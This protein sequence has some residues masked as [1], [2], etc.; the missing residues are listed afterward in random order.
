MGYLRDLEK[1]TKMLENVPVTYSF[2]EKYVTGLI[3]AKNVLNPFL[4]GLLLQMMAFH[5]YDTLKIV[6][7]TNDR[8]S[9]YWN[10]IINSPYFWD[11]Q[12]SIRFFGTNSDDISQISSYLEEM[13]ALLREDSDNNKSIGG[14]KEA[15]KLPCRYV[16][17]TDDIDAVR[18]VSIIRNVIESEAY[19]GISLI[20]CTDRLNSLPNEVEHF[21]SID[22][23]SGGV[24]EKVLIDDKKINFIPDFMFGSLEK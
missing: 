15:P 3:G 5:G 6:V 7:F 8:N 16:I 4:K 11:D 13:I 19:M 21:I 2:Q 23:K 17:I 14:N 22:E 1:E 20:I 9:K 10:D 12:K 18:N 24:F